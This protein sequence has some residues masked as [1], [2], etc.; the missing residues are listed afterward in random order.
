[1]KERKIETAKARLLFSL[2]FKLNY[3][4][5]AARSAFSFAA[6]VVSFPCSFV[7]IFDSNEKS[8]EQ[9]VI[10]RFSQEYC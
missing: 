4:P 9:A 6:I 7:F 2:S 10:S 5:T 1:M 8:S 3:F